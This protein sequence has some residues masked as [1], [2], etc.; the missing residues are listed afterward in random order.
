ML[1]LQAERQLRGFAAYSA[2]M[3]EKIRNMIA[4]LTHNR[5][6]YQVGVTG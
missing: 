5:S 4:N 1:S 3:L 2:K 6:P